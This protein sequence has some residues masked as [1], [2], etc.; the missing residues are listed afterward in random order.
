MDRNYTLTVVPK[1]FIVNCKKQ[2]KKND[3]LARKVTKM[4]Q[5]YMDIIY[6]SA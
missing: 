1:S 2:G 3:S 5:H 6:Q 4:G